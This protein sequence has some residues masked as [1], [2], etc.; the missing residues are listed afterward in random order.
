VTFGLANDPH[1]LIKR[2]D[3]GGSQRLERGEPE[4]D[5]G[6]ALARPPHGAELVGDRD[7]DPYPALAIG[8]RFRATD[9]SGRV[10]AIA[11]KAA[12]EIEMRIM[13]RI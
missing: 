8:V 10:S 6:Q 7:V 11:S 13:D 4:D 9:P 3:L 5:V 12:E 2:V 1:E